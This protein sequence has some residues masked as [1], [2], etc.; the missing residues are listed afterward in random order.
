MRDGVV[1]GV[2][3]RAAFRPQGEP[4]RGGLMVPQTVSP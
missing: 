4:A 1:L 2:G 3:V